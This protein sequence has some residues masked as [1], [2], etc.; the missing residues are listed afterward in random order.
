MRT[1]YWNRIAKVIGHFAEPGDSLACVKIE[2]ADEPQSCQLCDYYP[3]KWLHTLQNL[4]TGTALTIGSNCIVNYKKLHEQRFGTPLEVRFPAK[5]AKAATILNQ[6]FPGTVVV[7][8]LPDAPASED[9]HFL[10]I[11]KSDLD[12]L[13]PEGMGFDEIDWESFNWEPE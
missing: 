13:A 5:Y 2:K 7:D 8:Q 12:D 6:R 1:D 11:E 3:I 9:E 10:V 4:R